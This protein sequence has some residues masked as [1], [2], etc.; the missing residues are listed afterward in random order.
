MFS[1]DDSQGAE[2]QDDSRWR[3]KAQGLKMTDKA[4]DLKMTQDDQ[5]AKDINQ[6]KT[7]MTQGAGS[8]DD[9]RCRPNNNQSNEEQWKR[10]NTGNG[11]SNWQAMDWGNLQD[12]CAET[13][14]KA[15]KNSE[16]DVMPAMDW[17]IDGKYANL[18]PLSGYMKPRKRINAEKAWTS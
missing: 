9:S 6:N 5:Q 17:L 16:K 7:N 4:Q 10:R 1:Q 15:M 8:Q 2:S 3:L 11:L 13:T 18:C 12:R 14:I